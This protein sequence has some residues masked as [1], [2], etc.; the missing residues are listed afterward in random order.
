ML[1]IDA[2]MRLTKIHQ[3]LTESDK[4]IV[5][6]LEDLIVILVQ[7]EIIKKEDVPKIVVDKMYQRRKLR[8][9][10][11]ELEDIIRKITNKKD[12]DTG[13]IKHIGKL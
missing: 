8:K 13:G 9:E 10:L 7:K 12:M 2:R 6:F 11:M 1:P 3:E 4:A 5:R